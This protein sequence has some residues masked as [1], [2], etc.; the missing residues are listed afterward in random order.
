MQLRQVTLGVLVAV[1]A[2]AP[3]AAQDASSAVAAAAK[4]MGIETLTSITY[5]GSARSG[6]FGQCK[7]IGEPM[8]HRRRESHTGP[9]RC[10]PVGGREHQSLQARFQRLDSGPP[11]E[12][13]QA[14][15]QGGRPR[16]GGELNTCH[17]LRTSTSR[18]MK[19]PAC[20]AEG[21][22]QKAETKAFF[23]SPFCLLPSGCVFQQ[24]ASPL[25]A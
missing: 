20:K 9:A 16:G 15:D 21:I 5:S 7:A 4:A 18:L 3:A 17:V 19:K 23:P 2:V 6:A 11:A 14:A 10:G 24:P 1:A 8:G 22:R 13:G 25:E 12:S